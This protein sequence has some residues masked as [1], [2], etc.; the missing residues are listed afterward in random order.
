MS[1]QT[2][3]NEPECVALSAGQVARLLAI[4]VR[5]VWKLHASGRL[6]VP[7]RLGRSVR[8]RRQELLAWLDAD[9]P[10]RDRW[11]AAKGTTS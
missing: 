4:S 9:C 5:H 10:P 2:T 1:T 7:I 11:E 8:W 3:S 6:P